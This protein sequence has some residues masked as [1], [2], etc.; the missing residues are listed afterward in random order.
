MRRGKPAR[1]LSQLSSRSKGYSD[2][3]G[4]VGEVLTNKLMVIS[5]L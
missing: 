2:G 5:E 3:G 1:L 4:K